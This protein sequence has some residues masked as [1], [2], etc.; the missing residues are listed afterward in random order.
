MKNIL[1]FIVIMVSV[2]VFQLVT[3]IETHVFGQE[4]SVLFTFDNDTEGW[5]GYEGPVSHVEQPTAD[6]NGSLRVN[7]S[8]VGR[9]WSDNTFESPEMNKDFSQYREI[10]IQVFIPPQSPPGLKGQIFTKSGQNWTWRDNGWKPLRQGRWTTF[11]IPSSRIQHI[12]YVR[13]IGIKIGSNSS[14]NGEAYIDKVESLP[15]QA[16]QVKPSIRIVEIVTNSHIIGRVHGLNPS[17][18]GQYKIAVYVKTDKWYIH[19]YERGGEG[20]S[21]AKINRDGSWEV[22]TVKRR[23]L[24]DLVAALIVRKEYSPPSIVYDLSEIDSI[25]S[26]M[27]EGAGR[28]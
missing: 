13:T 12:N 5:A 3:V 18:Y 2:M 16:G 24:A 1:G 28:L 19:P 9:G 17:Q 15:A 10:R 7:V 14:Y 21:Y 8:L 23:F 25:G 11:S 27:E 26:Y 4:P 6:G 20:L 22:K